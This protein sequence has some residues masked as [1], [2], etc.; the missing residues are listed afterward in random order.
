MRDDYL[1]RPDSAQSMSKGFFIT[2]HSKVV[3][4]DSTYEKTV[5]CNEFSIKL[6]HLDHY[7]LATDEYDTINRSRRIM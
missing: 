6:T 5:C 3:A 7:F 1:K 2:N 4:S